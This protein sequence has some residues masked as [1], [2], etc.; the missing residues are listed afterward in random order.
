MWIGEGIDPIAAILRG[1]KNLKIKVQTFNPSSCRRVARTRV[2]GLFLAIAFVIYCAM[3]APPAKGMTAAVQGVD[4]R[5]A[6]EPV[7]DRVR[8]G[9]HIDHL[10]EVN[11]A[12]KR[13]TAEFDLWLRFRGAFD[14]NDL[15][16]LDTL[17]PLALDHPDE[18]SDNDGEHF[19]LFHLNAAFHFGTNRSD[20][21][22]NVRKLSIQLARRNPHADHFQLIPDSEGMGLD[23][24]GGS[25]GQTLRD[26]A[27]LPSDAGWEMQA[28]ELR[29][30]P[31]N[32]ER[33]IGRKPEP[34][35]VAEMT[36]R[37]LVVSP[38][39]FVSALLPPPGN[40][41]ALVELALVAALIAVTGS[42]LAGRIPRRPLLLIRLLLGTL[43]FYLLESWVMTTATE[44]LG[45]DSYQNLSILFQCLWWLVPALWINRLS[46]AF[47]WEPISQ[48]TGHPVPS[49]SRLIVQMVVYA[50]TL[51][52]AL[53]FVFDQSLGN[54]WAAS[55][56][57]GIILGIALQ[58]LILDAFAGFMLNTEQPFKILQWVRLESSD[59]GEQ[60]GQVLEMNW[61]TTRLWTR[62]NDI[63]SI[64]NSAVSKAKIT[65]FAV[66]TTA[67]RQEFTIVLD[68]YIP[69][70]RVLKI[71]KQGVLRAV[72]TGKVL[73]EPKQS[74]V[75]VAFE[76]P[77]IRYKILYYINMALVSR[78]RALGEVADGVMACLAEEGIDASLPPMRVYNEHADAAA[79]RPDAERSR[80]G[81][82]AAPVAAAEPE[83]PD[84][85]PISPEQVRIIRY[86]WSLVLPIADT[87]AGLF[88]ERLFQLDPGLKP[89]FRTDPKAQRVKL[90]SMLAL[91][92]KGIGNLEGLI[93]T[94]QEMGMRHVNYGVKDEHYDTVGEAFLWTLEQGL[95]EAWTPEAQLAW[96]AAY[97][98]LSSTMK[99]AAHA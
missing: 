75:V 36:V 46:P 39:V 51:M 73:A 57:M 56:V 81:E 32:V 47:V 67:S 61:R 12:A 79:S 4:A 84:L 59:I 17:K 33:R 69:T 49:I 27:V 7:A 25:W 38:K 8:V 99:S 53:R 31:V 82:L 35:L 9:L 70:A 88:Y 94:V 16:L 72:E 91:V 18:A 95:G 65:N 97:G 22:G 41:L 52:L 98:I 74:V 78:G 44:R 55:G 13:F 80:Q 90:I 89:M 45:F 6:K 28:G 29:S 40:G 26:D 71:L 60:V 14:A 76:N 10:S 43:G 3:E 37:K 1:Y 15:L 21:A 54:I 62:N 58:S 63:I 23:K 96:V 5:F 92:V 86:T 66:P 34:A 11:D 68:H 20:L 30:V 19:R 48:R 87:A 83:T 2:A 93:G 85:S 77:G 64:P 50:F 24:T 42:R